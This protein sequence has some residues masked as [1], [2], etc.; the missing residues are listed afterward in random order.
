MVVRKKAQST[1]EESLNIEAQSTEI[2]LYRALSI[3]GGLSEAMV[4]RVEE[5]K[6]LIDE[7]QIT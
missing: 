2:K 4:E 1:F 5:A 7:L 6:K 3:I